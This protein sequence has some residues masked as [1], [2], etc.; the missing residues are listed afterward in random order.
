VETINWLKERAE[1]FRQKSLRLSAQVGELE[2]TLAKQKKCLAQ[3]QARFDAGVNSVQGGSV[4]D[5]AEGTLAKAE[6][7]AYIQD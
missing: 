4:S 2:V 1:E 6:D 7:D 3:L 5:L